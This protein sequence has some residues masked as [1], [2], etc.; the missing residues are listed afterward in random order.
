MTK[1]CRFKICAPHVGS[2][3][4]RGLLTCC[5]YTIVGSFGKGKFDAN[6]P[7][8]KTIKYIEKSLTFSCLKKPIITTISDYRLQ[9]Y[10]IVTNDILTIPNDILTILCKISLACN[11]CYNT[12]FE[13]LTPFLTILT[14]FFPLHIEGVKKIEGYKC[15]IA[16]NIVNCDLSLVTHKKPYHNAILG[17]TILLVI[18]L[19]ISL[20]SLLNN[21]INNQPM[22]FT[23]KNY[24]KGVSHA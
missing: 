13:G 3:E 11:R 1:K 8:L 23:Y 17:L 9:S 18:S 12:I 21:Q 19:V 6:L 20:V 4:G 14:I 2:I 15:K 24:F 5:Y 16:K 10:I 22:V 7:T